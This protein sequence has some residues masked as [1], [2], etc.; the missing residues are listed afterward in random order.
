M[1]KTL[2]ATEQGKA[3]DS[4]GSGVDVQRIV[5]LLRHGTEE[6][7]RATLKR[8]KENGVSYVWSGD[9]RNPY[10]L[11]S[12]RFGQDAGLIEA[13]FVEYYEAQ[14]SGYRIKYLEAN[15]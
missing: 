5:S 15:K 10:L 9:L 4:I 8:A 11:E 2:E 14:E 6:E 13:E 1:M 3:S 7:H 12:L